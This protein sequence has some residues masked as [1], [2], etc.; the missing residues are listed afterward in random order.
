MHS[1][2]K[3]TGLMK[4]K[5][6]FDKSLVKQSALA[7][8][9]VV[10]IAALTLEATSV[11][12]YYFSRKGI[13]EEATLRAESQ[14][15]NTKLRILNVIDQAETAVRG[16]EWIARWCLDFPD[17]LSAVTRRIVQE[18]PVVVGSTIAIVPG[19]YKK[20]PLLA[21]YYYKNPE[22][23]ETILKSLATEEYDYPSQDWFATPLA[24]G[25][26]Y[27]SEP[28]IDEGG[29][30]MLMTTYSMPIR[31]ASGRIAAILTADVSLDWLSSLVDNL[32]VYPTAFSMMLS[33][34]GKIMVSPIDSMVMKRTFGDAVA[35][36][37]DTSA[38]MGINRAMLSGEKGESTFKYEGAKC[39]VFFAPVERT[40]WSMSIFVPDNE[41]YGNVKRVGL[42][43]SILQLL[44]LVMLILLLRGVIL[45]LLKY[46]NIN[47]TKE[48]MQSELRIASGIQMSMVPKIFPPFPERK[49]IDMSAAI[50]PAKE[51]GG[52]LYDFYI[53]DEK[54]YFCIGDVSGKG[55]PASLVMA[56]TRSL[57]RAESAHQD[58]PAKILEAMNNSMAEV[59]ENNMFVTFFCGVLDLGT[60]RLRY[61]N[62][63]HNAPVMLTDHKSFLPV[64]ANLALGIMGGMVYQEQETVMNYDDAIFLYTDGLTEAENLN[65]ELFGEERMDKVLSSRRSAQGHLEAMQEAVA[66]Y[67]GEAPQSDDL[68]MLF[69]H[70]L[71]KV[72]NLVLKNKVEELSRLEEFMDS[73]AEG[74][75]LDA[76][77]ATNINLALEE[78]VTNVVMYAYPEGTEGEVDIE[79]T[80]LDGVLKFVISDDGVPF[81]PTAVPE[82][83]VTLGVEERPIGGLG[84]F[85]VRKIMDSVEYC[86]ENGRNRLTMTKY[87]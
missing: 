86:R 5:Q 48:R 43:V 80:I 29:G 27:W 1:L 51:V 85:L 11:L 75:N 57:F 81:D 13:R 37:E 34:Q 78:A 55:V 58:S 16:S 4:I 87:I 59:N 42:M 82:A 79:A 56:V 25:E 67:V 52:D 76:A 54:L 68:T 33:R 17:S 66:E 69:I 77:T 70:Y 44:G 41:I 26:G 60:G 61:C 62:A 31:D 20:Q 12:Q 36:L 3:T 2:D 19:Y 14:L 47:D 49:D 53:R 73:V 71:K 21:P 84:I 83:D 30:D 24:S 50:V 74:C 6:V 15:E 23:G 38:L 8:L 65:H 18:N 28:Y 10:I 32:K 46:K 45:S 72:H 40:G 63:G 22:T 9:L 7:G 39:H 64:H 35:T